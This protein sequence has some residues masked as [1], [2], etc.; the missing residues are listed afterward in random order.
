MEVLNQK[1][2]YKD[3]P[4][5]DDIPKADYLPNQQNISELILSENL[6]KQLPPAVLTL[7]NLQEISIEKNP[8]ENLPASFFDLINLKSILIKKTEINTIPDIITKLVNLEVLCMP[9]NKIMSVSPFLL[10]EATPKLLTI[11]L[12]NNS[13]TGLFTTKEL[14]MK[15]KRIYLMGN[16]ISNADEIGGKAG[17]NSL[18]EIFGENVA[19]NDVDAKILEGNTLWRFWKHGKYPIISVF[20]VVL[21]LFIWNALKKS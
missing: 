17:R 8:I 3:I 16:P 6:F 13:I 20:I 2:I 21:I 1:L 14:A 9:N 5:L 15:E 12:E 7:A 11:R 18:T 10:T 19:F 4:L